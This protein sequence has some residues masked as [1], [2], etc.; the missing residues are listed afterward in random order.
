AARFLLQAQ[1]VGCVGA[2]DE[3]LGKQLSEGFRGGSWAKVKSLHRDDVPD[4]S[5]WIAGDGWWL[6]T[7]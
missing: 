7:K 2:R 5:C 3:A 6:S 1:F 4:E